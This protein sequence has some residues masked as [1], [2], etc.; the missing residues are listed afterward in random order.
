[1]KKRDFSIFIVML[2]AG[3]GS[4]S[5]GNDAVDRPTVTDV[6]NID[7]SGGGVR[8][9]ALQYCLDNGYALSP[10]VE[11]GVTR[12]YLCVNEERQKKCSANDFLRKKCVLE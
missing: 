10:M 8:N 9:P 5:V 4:V 12:Y 1:M 11:G 3:C 2:L 7:S 6:V